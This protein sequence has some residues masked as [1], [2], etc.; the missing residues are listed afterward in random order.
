MQIKLRKYKERDLDRHLELFLMNGICGKIDEKIREQ[1]K[2][3]LKKVIT[4]Y[5]KEKPD[6]F[7]IAIIL[8][9]KLIGNLVAEKIDTEKKTLEIGFW[10]GKNYWGKGITTK[11]LKI[12]LKKI[13]KK[14]KSK[15]II[16]HHKT[17][18]PASGRVL[19]KAGFNFESEKKGM[20]TY[21]K[22]C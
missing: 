8:K 4:N 12:F 19:E 10:I 16:A 22:I 13:I 18:N 2:E 6:F 17:N 14:F 5:K 15:K 11:A 7:I 3:W 20:K 1:E 21:S 9:G